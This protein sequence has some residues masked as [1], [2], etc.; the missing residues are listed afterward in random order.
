MQSLD[1]GTH[2]HGEFIH[3]LYVDKK[4]ASRHNIDIEQTAIN[5]DQYICDSMKLESP[6]HGDSLELALLTTCEEDRLPDFIL[7]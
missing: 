5:L 4:Y 3:K 6:E 2:H 1:H 7:W